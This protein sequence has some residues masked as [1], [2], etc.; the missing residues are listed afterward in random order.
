MDSNSPSSP[1]APASWNIPFLLAWFAGALGPQVPFQRLHRLGNGNFG[2][3]ILIS[4]VLFALG[5]VILVGLTKATRYLM[6]G[7]TSALRV[8][9]RWS[10]FSFAF[11]AL[12]FAVSLLES[13]PIETAWGG[14]ACLVAWFGSAILNGLR[15]Q[16]EKSLGSEARNG[17]GKG[18]GW[19]VNGVFWLIVFIVLLARDL[20][21]L[22]DLDAAHGWE[23]ALMALGRLLTLSAFTI[24]TLLVVQGLFALFP[25]GTKWLV[26]T[27]ASI[28][29]VIIIA[30]FAAGIY[31][32]RSLLAVINSFTLDG[33]FD[34]KKELEAAGITQSPLQVTLAILFLIG[35]SILAYTGLRRVR[36]PGISQL[37]TA[38]ALV[39]LGI[40]WLGA[41]GQ[42]AISML[43][44]RKEIWQAEHSAFKIH[45]GILSPDPGLETIEVAFRETQTESE[46]EALLATTP[47]PLKRKPDIYVIMVETWRSDAIT[48][49]VS[50]FLS[51]FRDE[52]CQQF[53]VTYAGSNCTPVSWYTLFHSRLGLSWKESVS[54]S[55]SPEGLVGAYP[56][57][58][59][60]K[61]GYK[62]S[63]RAVCDLDYKK[64]CD[65]NFGSDHK[66]AEHF[67][68]YTMLEHDLGIPKRERLI[69]D[70]LKKQL[71]NNP[72]GGRFHFVS[73]DSAHYNYYWPEDHFKPLHTDCAGNVSYGS[74]NPTKEEIR[75]VVKR[76]ENAVHWIDQQ[77]AEFIE[78][79]KSQNRYEDSLIILTGDH[80]E[81]FQEH[82]SWFHCSNLKRPQTEVP[83]MIKWPQ[84]VEKQPAQKQVSHLDVMPSVLEAL[85]LDEKYYRNLAGHSV[86]GE[87]PGESLLATIW[88]G[89][90]GVGVCMIK[91]G[92][93]ANLA[94]KS[95]LPGG[96]PESLHLMGYTGR[97][98]ELV[99]P[100]LKITDDK[101]HADVL[102]EY[103]PTLIKRHFTK[104]ETE[105]E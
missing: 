35:L 100:P 44:L 63:V 70:D 40:L 20:W 50:P 103:F 85:G 67:L 9:Y 61:L 53:D 86:L 65:L 98:D 4:V 94:I 104:F 32:K 47:A 92:V 62:F 23:A 11:A 22:S 81:E 43:T 39:L 12:I 17:K 64:M 1:K 49:E 72:R 33:V 5:V 102:R 90:S 89:V 105:E 30:D 101:R 84:W 80:G 75:E 25:V 38:R 88:S 24:A 19:Q 77:V 87:H 76:Y 68:D 79:L 60:H 95:L 91:D 21:A 41:I 78:F 71:L 36:L 15:A 54:K 73:L 2:Y 96:V 27:M 93:K 8:H 28:I 55:E 56:I 14:V 51:K 46:R 18:A 57:R 82:G 52:E 7:N 3:N 99:D 42:Q 58:L 13:V 48:P 97:D 10:M 6:A 31:W 69:F 37:R 29:P 45:L 66:Y 16:N 34:M 59:L 74:I 26:V 83:L